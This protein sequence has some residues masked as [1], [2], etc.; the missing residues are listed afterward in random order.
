MLNKEPAA[1]GRRQ[2]SPSAAVENMASSQPPAVSTLVAQCNAAAGRT[3]AVANREPECISLHTDGGFCT[4]GARKIIFA[5]KMF[6]R[7]QSLTTLGKALGIQWV[8]TDRFD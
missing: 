8:R 6:S 3:P 1:M 7:Y 4:L 2:V 5:F